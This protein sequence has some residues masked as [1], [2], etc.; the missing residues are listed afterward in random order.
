MSITTPQ[1]T[2]ASGVDT[3]VGIENVIGSKY[4][5]NLKG[6]DTANILTGGL[7][8][9][10]LTGGGGIDTFVFKKPG[11]GVDSINDFK[12]GVDKIMI[13]GN[14]FGISKLWVLT[15]DTKLPSPTKAEPFLL[16]NK[17]NGQ[18]WFDVD[19]MGAKAAA[20]LATLK[21]SLFSDART[22]LASDIL[23]NQKPIETI[24][25]IPGNP[26]LAGTL[27]ALNAQNVAVNSNIEI[28]FNEPVRAGS[29]NI[30]LFNLTKNNEELNISVTNTSQVTFSG[31]KMVI[32]PSA[33]LSRGCEFEVRF[34]SKVVQDSAGNAFEGLFSRDFQ[35]TTVETTPTD[36]NVPI[37]LEQL[38]AAGSR[39]TQGYNTNLTHRNYTNDDARWSVDFATTGDALA[40]ADGVVVDINSYTD[41]TAYGNNITIR[42]DVNEKVFYATYAHL[43]SVALTLTDST[44]QPTQVTAGQTVGVIGSSGYGQL[45][46]DWTPKSPG[47]GVHLHFQVS[48]GTNAGGRANAVTDKPLTYFY[49]L[50]TTAN[51]DVP[52]DVPANVIDGTR[53]RSTDIIGTSAIGTTTPPPDAAERLN[54][55]E[56]GE[57]IFALGGQDFLQG[58]NGNDELYG[59]SG[60]DDLKG[61]NG[62]D[63]LVGGIGN[64]AL[65]GGSGNDFAS[66]AKAT[67]AVTVDLAITTSQNTQG[68]GS[69]TLS[70]IE[71]L[72]GSQYG[73][74]LTGNNVENKISG[75]HGNDTLKGGAGNDILSGNQGDD[76]ISG[77]AGNDSLTGGIGK[78]TFIFNAPVTANI[79]R[80]TDFNPT[81]D[82]IRL[83]KA[84]FSKLALGQLN[85]DYFVIGTTAKD[86]NDYIIYN[87]ETAQLFYDADGNGAAPAVQFALLGVNLALT[88]ADFVVI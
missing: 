39:L 82:T 2:Y 41:K 29:G 5:D 34:D 11:D 63:L 86:G 72:T 38:P 81:D 59:G 83:G 54:G 79:D 12:S 18:L 53:L 65:D 7:G 22:L 33:D 60:N 16:Y 69:D 47:N 88:A 76:V 23:F 32:N 17:D 58:F 37:R 24:K 78:D 64:D 4:G 71:H 48:S 20:H 75:G 8:N 45:N 40:V 10:I 43:S 3:L 14:G 85:A 66:Y 61:G 36:V 9:D 56:Y 55:T 15:S 26:I 87:K 67:K 6:N 31:N 50:M 46:Y 52:D 1:T 49:G 57:R 35:F 77:D 73:D 25:D 28:T 44:G 27:P 13:D 84:V 51:G 74:T 19:G 30:T 68:A 80:I 62:D 70:N 21:W 42:H